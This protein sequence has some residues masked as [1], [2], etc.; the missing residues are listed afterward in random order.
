MSLFEEA[1][2][3]LLSKPSICETKELGAIMSQ[4]IPGGAQYVIC[5]PPIKIG[6]RKVILALQNDFDPAFFTVC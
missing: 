5:D 2:K 1:H 4:S 3:L 6:S